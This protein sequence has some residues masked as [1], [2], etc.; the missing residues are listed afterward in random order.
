MDYPCLHRGRDRRTRI[1]WP[2]LHRLEQGI[3][4]WKDYAAMCLNCSGAV[5]GAGGFLVVSV[6]ILPIKFACETQPLGNATHT[7]S[8]T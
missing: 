3:W 4:G 8:F 2:R 6:D 1:V 5:Q 7:K